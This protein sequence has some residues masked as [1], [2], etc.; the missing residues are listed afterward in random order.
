MQWR[1]KDKNRAESRWD[2]THKI[3]FIQDHFQSEVIQMQ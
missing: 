2:N 3:K 1:V